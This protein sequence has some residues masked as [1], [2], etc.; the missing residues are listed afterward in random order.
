MKTRIIGLGNTLLTDDGV[1][2]Y[3]AR[4]AARRLEETGREDAADII[5]AE[6]AGFGLM[7]LMNGWERVILVD[8]VQFAGVDAG[9]VVQLDPQDLHTSLR[10]RSV[11]EIDLPTVLELGHLLGL[12]MPRRVT[13]FGIQAEDACTFG[14]RLTAAAARGLETATELVLGELEA[15]PSET[16]LPDPNLTARTC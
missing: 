8:S 12:E 6:V 11:H 9:T 15:V 10:I 14:E 7:E 16:V 5:E 3:V 2:V 4:E 1:G 13:V